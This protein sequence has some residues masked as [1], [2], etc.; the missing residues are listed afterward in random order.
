MSTGLTMVKWLALG[1]AVGWVCQLLP[2]YD[3][4]FAHQRKA[5]AALYDALAAEVRASVDG[6]SSTHPWPGPLLAARQAL[7]VLP[8]FSRLAASPLFGLVGEA[9]RIAQHLRALGAWPG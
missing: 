5:V 3:P 4:R 8:Q 7:S 9:Q 6:G 1:C 2:P